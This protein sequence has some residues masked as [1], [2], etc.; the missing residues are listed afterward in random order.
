MSFVYIGRLNVMVLRGQPKKKRKFP[1]TLVFD[2]V[3]FYSVGKE[4]LPSLSDVIMML[5]VK[6]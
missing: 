2:K 1:G 6:T 3:N 4:R 5:E